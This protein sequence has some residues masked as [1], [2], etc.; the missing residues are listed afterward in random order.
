M[1]LPVDSATLAAFA[2]AK[3]AA[4]GRGAVV[5][6]EGGSVETIDGERYGT[7]LAYLHEASPLFDQVGRRWPGRTKAAVETYDPETEVVVIL[8]ERSGDLDAFLLP[9]DSAS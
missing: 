9:L 5:I 1:N 2:R 8:L 4:F 3:F 7:T 6:Q